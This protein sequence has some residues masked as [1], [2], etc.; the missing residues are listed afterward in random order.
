VLTPDEHWAHAALD[1][2]DNRVGI[3]DNLLDDL[4]K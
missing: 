3:L 4:P 2:I 1:Y